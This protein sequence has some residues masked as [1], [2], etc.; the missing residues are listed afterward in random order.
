MGQRMTVVFVTMQI[1]LILN[2]T[3]T[4]VGGAEVPEPYGKFISVFD[5]MTLGKGT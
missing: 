4:Q 2:T 1:I 5:F 3:H